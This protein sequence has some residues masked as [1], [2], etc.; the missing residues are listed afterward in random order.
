MN[1]TVVPWIVAAFSAA[2]FALMARH[3]GRSWAPWGLAGGFFALI[4]TTIVWGVG[5]AAGIPFSDHDRT[6]FH[7]RWTLESLGLVVIVMALL[8]LRLRMTSR[9]QATSAELR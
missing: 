9:D 1:I 6:M 3:F 5:H 2:C 4:V 8:A 7:L